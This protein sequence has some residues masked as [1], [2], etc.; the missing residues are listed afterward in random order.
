MSQTGGKGKISRV[1]RIIFKGLELDP[2]SK[3]EIKPI[4]RY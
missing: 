4:Y 1:Y 2:K 3:H